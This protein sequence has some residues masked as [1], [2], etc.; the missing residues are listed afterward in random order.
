[1]DDKFMGYFLSVGIKIWFS[2]F[3]YDIFLRPL[4]LNIKQMYK[5]YLHVAVF[6]LC[7]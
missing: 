7:I 6:S 1:M 4:Q 2:C 3:L 5:E